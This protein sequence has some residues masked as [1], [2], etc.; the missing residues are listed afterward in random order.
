MMKKAFTVLFFVAVFTIG[1]LGV[2]TEAKAVECYNFNLV[3]QGASRVQGDIFEYSYVFL[4]PQN[5]DGYLPVDKLSL[6]EFGIDE[7]LV[8]HPINN[9]PDVHLP[10]EGGKGSEHWLFGIPQLQVLTQSSQDLSNNK[11]FGI[12]VSGT[13]GNVGTVAVH[14]QAGKKLETCFIDGP[15]AG[16]P[17]DVS[18]PSSETVVLND[19][20]YCIDLN[21]RTGCPVANPVVYVCGTDPNDP[22]NV[23]EIDANFVLGHDTG[24]PDDLHPPTIIHGLGADPRCP[25]SKA[26]HNPCQWI[27]IGGNAYGPACW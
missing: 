16:L 10:G 18:I 22:A 6:L 13:G 25:I 15:V 11:P 4:L 12:Q 21:P 27:I 23:L 24:D 19:V 9:N 17:V 1:G 20:E 7:N 26:A 5:G 14:T 3:F 2:I 8:V